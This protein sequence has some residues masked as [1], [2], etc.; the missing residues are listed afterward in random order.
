MQWRH[1]FEA[2]GGTGVQRSLSSQPEMGPPRQ[3]R[4]LAGVEALP[5]RTRWTYWGREG[6]PLVY[7][8]EQL[9]AQ[10]ESFMETVWQRHLR[11]MEDSC[12]SDSSLDPGDALD[13]YLLA[14]RQTPGE[15]RI[16]RKQ[17]AMEE[18]SMQAREPP[19]FLR[20]VW[21]RVQR[22]W[23]TAEDLQWRFLGVM[24]QLRAHLRQCNQLYMQWPGKTAAD[25]IVL[26]QP[27]PR[28]FRRIWRMQAHADALEQPA[29][30][31]PAWSYDRGSADTGVPRGLNA[32]SS[33]DLR[34][35]A[36]ARE[37]DRSRSRRPH[38][39][40]GQHRA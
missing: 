1:A 35:R 27:M 6:D 30:A 40:G 34:E 14:R 33:R 15:T 18:V 16:R 11:H 22:G 5:A 26:F 31:L 25:A 10:A 21:L 36:Q 19:Q 13:D 7:S 4:L 2:L 39:R 3:R 32:R 37:Q 9:D 17:W 24:Y 29:E 38:G 28:D 20:Q 12:S 23:I 8:P